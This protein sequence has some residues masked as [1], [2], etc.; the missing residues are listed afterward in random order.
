MQ[1]TKGLLTAEVQIQGGKLELLKQIESFLP[2]TITVRKKTIIPGPNNQNT[3][4]MDVEYGPVWGGWA[5]DIR[6]HFT[7]AAI[8]SG[9]KATVMI[10]RVKRTVV[11][12]RE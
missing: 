4:S 10:S 9:T 2:G 12:T 5:S 1:K 3:I 8:K 6:S 7:R 11:E